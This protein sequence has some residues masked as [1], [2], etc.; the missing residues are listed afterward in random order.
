[1]QSLAPPGEK[2]LIS[3]D[4]KCGVFNAYLFSIPLGG[5]FGLFDLLYPRNALLHFCNVFVGFTQICLAILIVL[6]ISSY[7]FLRWKWLAPLLLLT[8]WESFY[9]LP[10]PAY[11]QWQY[12]AIGG[13]MAEITL[14]LRTM[15]ALKRTNPKGL[16]CFSIESTRLCEFSWKRTFLSLFVKVFILVPLLIVYVVF[17]GQ[18]YIREHSAGFIEI[19]KEGVFTEART[20][21]KEGHN[22]YLLP[23]VHIATPAFYDSLMESLPEEKTVILPEG[24]T[25]LKG[26]LKAGLD[27]SARAE[28]VGLSSQPDLTKRSKNFAVMHVDCDVSEFSP[29]TLSVLNDVGRMLKSAQSIQNGSGPFSLEMFTPNGFENLE[30]F[31]LEVL[32]KD[33]LDNRNAKLVQGINLAI[34]THQHIAV[35]WGAAHMPGIERALLAQKARKISSKRVAVFRWSEIKWPGAF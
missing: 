35:P 9:L 17:S 16:P 19:T 21:E 15:A 4:W 32:F 33:V 14:G 2:A 31:D 23:T 25:D 8:F 26:L 10:L 7:R 27:Y 3:S 6:L 18:I 13:C 28:S 20:Y 12:I 5:L 30:S 1:M 29:A 34:K 11:Y 24:V 22:I